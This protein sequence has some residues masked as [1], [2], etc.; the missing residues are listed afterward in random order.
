MAVLKALV[1]TLISFNSQLF[2]QPL[3]ADKKE[4]NLLEGNKEAPEEGTRYSFV[5]FNTDTVYAHFNTVYVG[6]V[7][8]EQQCLFIYSYNQT[9]EVSHAK[10]F[11]CLAYLFKNNQHRVFLCIQIYNKQSKEKEIELIKL[12]DVVT[13]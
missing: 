8:S 10:L 13:Q 3:I 11:L 5:Q 12:N 1:I 9:N 7:S 4:T 2:G 6:N